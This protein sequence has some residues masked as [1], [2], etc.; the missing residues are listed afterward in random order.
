MHVAERTA[1]IDDDKQ[2]TKRI[3]KEQNDEQISH[4]SLQITQLKEVS[5]VCFDPICGSRSGGMTAIYGAFTLFCLL[6]SEDF[7]NTKFAFWCCHAKSLGPEPL[8]CRHG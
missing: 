4:L 6:M 1:S 8:S 2:G 7:S 5:A 3:L